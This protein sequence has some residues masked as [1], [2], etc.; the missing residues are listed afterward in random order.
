MPS[1][2]Q[3]RKRSDL[4][5]RNGR[6]ART[7]AGTRKKRQVG[8]G[9]N[10]FAKS[11][12]ELVKPVEKVHNEGKERIFNLNATQLKR[13]NKRLLT[14]TRYAHHGNK[15]KEILLKKLKTIPDQE[16]IR[17]YLHNLGYVFVGPKLNRW[18]WED[19]YYK[20]PTSGVILNTYDITEIFQNKPETTTG[21]SPNQIQTTG[22]SPN[23]NQTTTY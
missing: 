1:R 13:L 5:S 3:T 21:I 8:G 18:G 23:N 2:R 4:R 9:W 19:D 12:P 10:P 20:N 11:R 14:N 17:D 16:S 22:I 6:S 7:S 15:E